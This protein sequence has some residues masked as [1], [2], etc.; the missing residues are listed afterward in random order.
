[1]N[2]TTAANLSVAISCCRVGGYHDE[3]YLYT[4]LIVTMLIRMTK[5]III[6]AIV[7][8]HYQQ[9]S[10]VANGRQRMCW[11]FAEREILQFATLNRININKQTNKQT[12]R[13]TNKQT[14]KQT[15]RLNN[16]TKQAN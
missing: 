1:M 15:N 9:Q 11:G 3:V 14:N 4:L 13:Q 10:K 8:Q 7:D 6:I 12:D 5:D 2:K 16:Q